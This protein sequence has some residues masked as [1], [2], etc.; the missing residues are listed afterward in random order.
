MTIR[1]KAKN[2]LVWLL[3]VSFVE[4]SDHCST[5]SKNINIVVIK[6]SNIAIIKI[7]K[8]LKHFC[9][10][11]IYFGDNKRFTLGYHE[12]SVKVTTHGGICRR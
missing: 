11:R 4:C 7:R 1:R 5:V 9:M 12:V 6:N 10:R 8:Q 3:A 2:L